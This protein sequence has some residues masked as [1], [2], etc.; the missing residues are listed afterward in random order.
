TGNLVMV[1]SGTLNVKA[2]ATATAQ[3]T[4]NASAHA[5]GAWQGP[6]ATT[7]NVASFTN[8]GT[9]NVAAAAAA[10]ALTGV[11]NATAF[12]YLMTQDVVVP[13]T[14]TAVNSGTIKVNATA[15]APGTAY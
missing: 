14:V 5:T 9:I 6:H 3:E 8:S 1:N 4:A 12:G 15:V 10:T 11:A 7:A 2:N 13:A